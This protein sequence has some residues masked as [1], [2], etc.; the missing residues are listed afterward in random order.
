VRH[1]GLCCR[2]WGWSSFWFSPYA[3]PDCAISVAVRPAREFCPG[4]AGFC[5]RA[6]ACLLRT[7]IC[8]SLPRRRA[9]GLFAANDSRCQLLQPRLLPRRDYRAMGSPAATH[10]RPLRALPACSRSW[11]AEKSSTCRDFRTANSA[12]SSILLPRLKLHSFL[13]VRL[14]VRVGKIP[15]SGPGLF[16]SSELS[17]ISLGFQCVARQ[18]SQHSWP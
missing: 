6:G 12:R 5:G 10:C 8:A 18:Y 16:R 11:T 4:G 15:M 17:C 2:T 3:S 9:R 14:S 1:F 7:Q 13:R